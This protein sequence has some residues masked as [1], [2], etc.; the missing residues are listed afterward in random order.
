MATCADE[1]VRGEAPAEAAGRVGAEAL[2][3]VGLRCRRSRAAA[4]GYNVANGQTDGR[5]RGSARG[6][7]AAP[8]ARRTAGLQRSL[9]STQRAMR[10]RLVASARGEDGTFEDTCRRL[11][12]QA[13][14]HEMSERGQV[15]ERWELLVTRAL[16]VNNELASRV[17]PSANTS[18]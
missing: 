16:R 13:Y 14:P 7:P 11:S 17:C 18:S 1:E 2:A 6:A 8:G 12:T 4:K 9:W 5:G 3:S 15:T 10:G